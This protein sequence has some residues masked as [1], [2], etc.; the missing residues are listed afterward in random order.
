MYETEKKWQIK[1]NILIRIPCPKMDEPTFLFYDKLVIFNF[2]GTLIKTASGN[3]IYKNV[4]DWE[5]CNKKIITEL[6]GLHRKKYSLVILSS[7]KPIIERKIPID[8][9]KHRTDKFCEKLFSSGIPA[10]FMIATENNFCNKPK[11]GL[12]VLLNA[13]FRNVGIRIDKEKSLCIGNNAAR[14]STRKTSKHGRCLKDPNYID[15]AFAHNIGIDFFTP[16]QYFFKSEPRPFQY[17]DTILSIDEKKTFAETSAKFGTENYLREGNVGLF[18][19]KSFPQYPQYMI[20]LIGNYFS[21][22]TT[23]AN[24]IKDDH[25]NWNIIDIPKSRKKTTV[26]NTRK[27]ICE[28]LKEGK[29]IILD[30]LNHR[31]EQ[32]MTY[33]STIREFKKV[34]VLIVILSTQKKV[35]MHLNEI[36]VDSSINFNMLPTKKYAY[37]RYDKEAEILEIEN[38]L[39]K[40]YDANRCKVIK[41]KFILRPEL[42][43]DKWL[44][45]Y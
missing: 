12:W 27:N 32:R 20:V 9:V 22:K 28:Q 21:G 8:D 41:H 44:N 29:N 14:L 1:D 4:D 40:E 35:C 39:N 24:M 23:L 25:K 36:A 34:A 42:V 30:G 11:I 7:E 33:I 10:I 43:K 18:L 45:V 17:P 13:L 31:K 19:N 3:K 15:R 26:K 38:D 16:E 2:D 37:N 6:V 5:L